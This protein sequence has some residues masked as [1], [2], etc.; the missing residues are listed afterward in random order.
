MSLPLP[1]FWAMPQ[2]P[3]DLALMILVGGLGGFGHLLLVQALK[4]APASLLAPFTYA[5]IVIALF[6]GF[7]VFGAVPD[8]IA[9]T[10]I[11]LI[12]VTGVVMAIR[13]RRVIEPVED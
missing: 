4:V 9:L 8:A 5:H 10:G 3:A 7:F 2:R 13:Q 11:A 12:V 6:L 1:F